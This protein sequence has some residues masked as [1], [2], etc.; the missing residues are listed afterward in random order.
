[1]SRPE[2]IAAYPEEA[3]Q[4]ASLGQHLSDEDREA[5]FD[6]LKAMADQKKEK[7]GPVSMTKLRRL[8]AIMS[9]LGVT[10]GETPRP[11]QE[12]FTEISSPE[13]LK[14]AMDE[15]LEIEQGRS[16]KIGPPVPGIKLG[17]KKARVRVDLNDDRKGISTSALRRR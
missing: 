9:E 3:R 10:D 1:M 13:F 15:F 11:S 12:F 4:D 17:L 8:K 5:L 14:S 16:D 6:E 2:W 7:P